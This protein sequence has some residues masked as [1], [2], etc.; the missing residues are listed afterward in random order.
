ME[1][2]SL[3]YFQIGVSQKW[4]SGNTRLT[5]LPN[6]LVTYAIFFIDPRENRA[7]L[8]NAKHKKIVKN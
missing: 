1:V 4:I 7:Y 2:L 3:L 5:F 8:K 6:V